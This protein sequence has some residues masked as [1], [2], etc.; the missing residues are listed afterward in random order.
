MKNLS[1]HILLTLVLVAF[2]IVGYAQRV[3]LSNFYLIPNDKQVSLHWTIDAGPT[4]NG[5]TVLHS[6]DSITYS[7]VGNI[8]G[9]CGSSS[10]A[11]PYNYSHASPDLNQTNFYKI[12]LGYSQFSD[13]KTV[14]VKY[15]EPGKIIIKPNPSS[16]NV[17]IEFNN[18]AANG[19]L[20][21]ITNSSGNTVYR[22][23]NISE[24]TVELNTTGWSA[25][26][27]YVTLAEAGG[28][29]LEE[30]LIIVK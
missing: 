9:V 12:R 22:K 11:I 29:K 5:I 18:N 14:H 7:E 20:L 6:T 8:G 25:S 28:K 3:N 4:C 24:S 2:S 17:V 13:V 16:D 26:T 21:T 1:R 15:T 27:Y 30:K 23:E 10:S 19:Y